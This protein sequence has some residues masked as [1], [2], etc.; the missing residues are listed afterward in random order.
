MQNNNLTNKEVVEHFFIEGCNN[1]NYDH[2]RDCLVPNYDDH[3]DADASSAD[4]AVEI[5]MSTHE[6]F[7]DIE[8][9]IDE[10]IEEGELVAFR[11]HFSGTHKGEFIGIPASGAKV[12]FEAL[13]IFKVIDGKI[14][15]SWGYWPNSK[16][17]E[18]IQ[19]RN[20]T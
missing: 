6:A 2:V 3:G 20:K 7:P 8:V 4:K 14:I 12:R 1:Q 11:G 15:E 10:L 9:V 18:Q 5:L 19:D 13:E 16:I 17:V